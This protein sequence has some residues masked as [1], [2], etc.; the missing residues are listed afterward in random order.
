MLNEKCILVSRCE[1][2]AI[3]FLINY[4]LP[5]E[6]PHKVLALSII[7]A[8]LHIACE[9]GDKVLAK[10]MIEKG[11]NSWNKSLLHACEG[12]HID[13]ALLMILRGANNLNTAM[14]YA[15]K[16]GHKNIVDL[17]IEKGATDWDLGLEGAC[18]GGH[19]EIAFLM[20]KKGAR[21]NV[22]IHHASVNKHTELVTLMIEKKG[23]T[24][25]HNYYKLYLTDANI[26]YLVQKG[27]SLYPV[28][29]STMGFSYTVTEWKLFEEYQ[30]VVDAFKKTREELTLILNDILIDDL[31]SIIL[32]F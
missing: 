31:I 21:L 25:I 10:L 30:H 11:A 16:G 9:R 20:I 22:G 7:N 14:A 24:D 26:Y 27:I 19:N 17:M 29:I 18:I 8:V 6:Y 2:D 13:L 5:D 12:G 15:C 3:R 28:G 23:Y 1:M 4:K 32:T